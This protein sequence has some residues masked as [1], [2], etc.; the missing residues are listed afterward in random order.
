MTYLPAETMRIVGIVSLMLVLMILLA[1]VV[2]RK[3]IKNIKETS[4]RYLAYKAL[5]EKYQYLQVESNTE[6]CECLE[7][8]YK[9]DHFNFDKYVFGCVCKERDAFEE[10]LDAIEINKKQLAKFEEEYRQ[11]P[12]F[13]ETPPSWLYSV[14]ERRVMKDEEKHRELPTTESTITC[15]IRYTSPAGRNRYGNFQVYSTEDIEDFVNQSYVLEKERESKEYQRK[16]LTPSLRYD[17]LKRDNFKCVICG[18]TPKKDGVTLHVDHIIPVS[19]GGK[20]EPENLRTLCSICNLGK[21]DRY[22]EDELN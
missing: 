9:F 12:E 16:I 8:K 17:I 14:L 10:I 3:T 22:D 7:S 13:T 2:R 15:S 21:S 20:T 6:Y 4:D 1:I 19:K 5:C 11:L 18:R